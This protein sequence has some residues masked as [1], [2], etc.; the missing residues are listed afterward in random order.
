MHEDSATKPIMNIAFHSRKFVISILVVLSTMLAGSAMGQTSGDYNGFYWS[1]NGNSITV[2]GNDG[3]LDGAV[4]IPSNVPVQ[5]GTD[6]NGS[7]TYTEYS[8]TGIGNFAFARY[9]SLTSVTIPDSVTS[10]GEGVFEYCGSLTSVTI[11]NSVTSIGQQAFF[12]CTN[13]ASVTIPDSVTSIGFEAFTD[14]YNLT[15]VTIGN[16]VTSIGQQ[17]FFLCTNLA[18]VTIPN[19]VTSIGDDA[20]TDC[21]N[22][23]SVT[24]GNSVTSIG[25]G[26]FYSCFRLTSVTIPDS[27]TSSMGAYAFAYCHGLTNVM[28]GNGV[29]SIGDEA[30]YLCYGLTSVTIGNSV[31]SIGNLAFY[32]CY[33]LTSVTIPNSV[34][35]I[36]GYAF[37]DCSGLTNVCFV[38]NAPS[39]G[40]SIFSSDVGLSDIYYVNGATGWGSTYDGI[41]TASCAQCDLTF[42]DPGAMKA[43]AGSGGPGTWDISTINWWPGGTEDVAWSI[44]GG[45]AH[46]AGM[47]GTVALGE[48]VSANG[49]TFHT[50]GYV[51]TGANAITLNN[52]GTISVPA[53]N[54]SISCIIAGTSG[55][56]YSGSGALTLSG[57]NTYTGT[58]TIGSGCTLTIAGAGSLG[59][60]SYAGNIDN[61]GT[62]TY[63]SS[64]AQTLS[65]V[66]S[67][68][69]ALTQSGSGTL[70][71]SRANTY[72]G[73]TTVNSGTLQISGAG[74][75]GDR[76][77]SLTVSG[78]TLD[79]GPTS[80]QVGAVK[81]SGGTIQNGSPL[82]GLTGLNYDGES[83]TVNANLAGSSMTKSGSEELTLTGRNMFTGIVAINEGSL[84][85]G[86]N[87]DTPFTPGAIT[88]MMISIGKG[89]TFDVSAIHNYVSTTALAAL[90]VGTG[91]TAATIKGASDGTVSLWALPIQL[92][93]S[94]T[95]LHGDIAHPSLYISQRTLSLNGNAFT[96]ITRPDQQM[97]AG[98]YRLIEQASGGIISPGNSSYPPP[99]LIGGGLVAGATASIQVIGGYVNLVVTQPELP[100]DT[101]NL[102]PNNQNVIINHGASVN[103]PGNIQGPA[104]VP[105][106]PIGE[107]ISVAINGLLQTTEIIDSS[108]DFYLLFNSSTIPASAAPYII[109]YLYGGDAL[110]NPA[111]NTNTTLTVIKATP[112][113]T[114]T[115]PAAIIYGTALS[116][117]QLNA[118]AN[119]PGSF[120]Y[121]PPGGSILNAGNNSL[122]VLFTPLDM[123][124]YGSTTDTVTLIVLQ[125]TPSNQFTFATN[126]GTIT[127]TGYT[128]P[129]GPVSIPSNING[130]PV[131]SIGNSASRLILM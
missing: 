65:G 116:S 125:A 54:T 70:T 128:G 100:T 34:T 19:S 8:V 107:T 32:F 105:P 112:L 94:P 67:D 43:P 92:T 14:C 28:I 127:I 117:N 72:I 119:V 36:G 98:I 102:P 53:G 51:I 40:G 83:G 50:G 13:L 73:G 82:F 108:G 97:G 58:T 39:D 63:S 6:T 42:W 16:S 110:F 7:P 93:F 84:T 68:T 3:S 87:E 120:A 29:T 18:S 20:F 122:S 27:V 4:A 52:P 57:A 88:A 113:I 74:T 115:N 114:W 90:G 9:T 101:I 55:L 60:G 48:N 78:G 91:S 106:V 47:A 124:D 103:L 15:S 62:F 71:L 121:T 38:G 130:Y 126:N 86:V 64:A 44:G 109:T 24:I 95:S 104:G 85:L 35:S 61:S 37:E 49:L 56:T 11:G 41:P 131:A 80:Q 17:A 31:T 123:V 25:E 75:L 30:F 46:F 23:T 5:T 81:I 10:I 99:T 1:W 26:V 118:T 79:L 96:V 59:S 129:R 76:S 33:R 45:Y 2:T 89:A 22:L 66:I 21:Y 111:I 69:G 12:F 77:G